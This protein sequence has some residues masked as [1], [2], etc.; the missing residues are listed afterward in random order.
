MTTMQH[1]G[2]MYSSKRSKSVACSAGAVALLAM[3]LGGSNAALS[4]QPA[5]Q[6]PIILPGDQ[7][8]LSRLASGSE[9]GRYLE[10]LRLDFFQLDADTDGKLTQRDIDLHTLMEAIQVRTMALNFV[11]RLD[12]D[13]DGAV[14]EDEIRRTMRYEQRAQL[15]LAASPPAGKPPIDAQEQI[16]KYVR[17]IMALD[18]DKDGKVTFSEATKY[19]QPGLQ[20]AAGQSGLSARVRQVMTLGTQAAGELSLADYQAAGEALFRKIDSDNDGKVSQQELIDYRRK[21]EPPDMKTRSEAADAA[22]KRLAE[23]AESARKKQEAIEAERVACAMP[24]ASATAKVVLLGTHETDALSSVTLGSQDNVV[25]AGRV[26]VEPGNEP[27]YVVIA[28]YGPA[29]WQFSGAVERIERLI[30]S[31]SVTGPGGGSDPRQSPLVGATGISSERIT[32][33]SR[34]NCL[35]HFS[36]TPSSASLQTAAAI[37]NA[38]GKTPEVI[39]AKYSVG[40]YGIPSGKIETLR[41][42]RQQPLVI[43]KSQGSLSI[44]G[45]PSN[46]IIQ[47]GPSRAQEEMDGFFPGGVTDIDA[48]TVIARAPAAAYEVFPAQA[49]LVQLLGKGTLTQNRTGE[50]IVREKIRFPPGLYGAHAVTFLVLKGTPYP[51]G[52]PA[53][54]CVIVEDTGESKGANCRTR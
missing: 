19:G 5:A 40:S 12:L 52:D 36:E 17:T 32:F 39:V 34:S 37:S 26:I 16:E 49:G 8:L 42:Q 21:P 54:S 50:Y 4:Q 29:I 43:R 7:L 28:S 22:Q 53:H 3:L 47:T 48:K 2:N 46:V 41:E 6:P 23:Q 9:L 30:M 20:R 13:G 24:T 14:T 51:D 44:V 15:A 1:G 18:T 45:N 33:L 35:S 38:T 11:M 25:H 10:Q 27:L 31:S